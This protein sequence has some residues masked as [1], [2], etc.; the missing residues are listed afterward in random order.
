MPRIITALSEIS[1]NYDAMF[2][3]LWGCVHNGITAFDEAVAA[4]RAYRAG[5]GFVVLV[6]NSPKPRA[7][8]AAQLPDFG[9]PSD[10]YDTIATSGDSA[11]A[12]MF[13]GAVGNKVYFMGEWERDAGF[14]EPMQV[15]D[16]PVEITRVPVAEA[17]GIV[18]CGPFDPMA[19]PDTW[20]ADL[21]MAKQMGAKLLCANPDII[22]DRGEA[23]EWCAGAVARMY[24]EMGG[25][26]LYFGKPHPPIYDLARRRML[27]EG[28][29]IPNARILA[30]GDGIHTDIRGALGEDIDSLF[31]TGG[32]AREETGT[33]TQPDPVK[34][35]QFVAD[36]QISPSFAIG[37]LR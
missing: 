19:D 32:L 6:T 16:T 11:R 26:S 20:R 9:V 10:C 22:V 5:G 28:C 31:I 25:E 14:F 29:D 27:A 12:A 7:G 34:L 13:T 4:L 3:D 15:I 2:V 23:R 18:C 37:Y 35:A 17:E 36:E 33:L 8:V 24:T 21:M 1:A 30:I